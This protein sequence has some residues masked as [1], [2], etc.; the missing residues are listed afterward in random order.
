MQRKL[1]RA[2][3]QRGRSPSRIGRAGR[4]ACR[5]R[6][7]ERRTYDA[8]ARPGSTGDPDVLLDHELE[9]GRATRLTLTAGG[10][11]SSSSNVFG[12]WVQPTVSC[13]SRDISSYSAFWVG[14]GGLTQGCDLARADRHRVPT[15]QPSG[16]PGVFAGWYEILPAWLR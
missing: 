10:T 13:T 3:C 6:L 7:G 4:L 1:S 11:V 9:L 14:L 8:S 15:A 2:V 16:T 12:T 5:H